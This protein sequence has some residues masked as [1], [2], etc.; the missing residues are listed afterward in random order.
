MEVKMSKI[1]EQT[2]QLEAIIREEISPDDLNSHV[3]YFCSIGEIL[4]G[5]EEEEKACQYIID[6]LTR[7]GVQTHVHEFESYVS[8]PVSAEFSVYFPEIIDIEGV[9]VSFGVSTPQAGLSADVVFVG[10]GKQENYFGVD[11]KGKIVLLEKLP[12]PERAV[13][14]IKNGAIAMI[15][16]SQGK[17]QHKMIVTPVWGTP[18]F[19]EKDRIPRIPVVSISG[20]QGKEL[21]DIA[22]SGNMKGTVKTK[23]REGWRTL[24][25]PV[26]EIKGKQPEFVLAGG[27][28]CSWFDGSTDN[29]T[30]DSCLVEMAKVLNKHKENFTYGVRLA[31]W[32]GHSHGRY[33]GSTWYSDTF[34]QE[35]YDNGIVYF[36]IDSPGVKGA[37]V[38][39]PRHQ[40]A[41]ISE[42]NEGCVAELT[43]WST[44]KTKEA[45]LALG[46]RNGKY[47]NA[48]RPSRAA[49]QSFWGI[50]LTSLG[51]YSMLPPDHPDRDFNVG[52][53][54]G[55][56][57]WHSAYET[58]DKADK[59][60][61][62]QDTRLYASIVTR[63]ATA[64]VMPFDFTTLAGDYLDALREYEEETSQWIP[65]KDLTEK[66]QTLQSKASKLLQKTE[67]MSGSEA[68]EANRFF[69]RLSRALNPCLYT[70]VQQFDHQPALSTRFL[71]DLAPALKLKD[72]DPKSNDFKFLV[73]QL[74]RKV[75][76]I[77]FHILEATRMI[78]AYIK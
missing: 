4:A 38:Y 65:F 32:P 57:W 37:T 44:V 26:A 11:A 59:N 50:G 36:N 2:K 3:E 42:F 25:V 39:V 56:W 48:T 77:T 10:D 34:W 16:M 75:T 41:E 74:K 58:V 14:A 13:T 17:M 66:V 43:E 23:N 30:G 8:H 62:A 5:T 68:L 52:G 20:D 12:S 1:S 35:L 40:M 45:Q 49:D 7:A 33:S 15:C 6:E 53:S 28:Y 22:R 64:S 63:L 18:S 55:A 24:R 9:G 71:P 21:I 72:M 51:V 54:G 73:T 60:I 61:L 31:W 78:E 69:L 29:A 70:E 47:V 46:R 76:K 67:N 19:A 27:H